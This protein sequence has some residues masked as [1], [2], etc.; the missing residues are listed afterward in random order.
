MPPRNGMEW[1]EGGSEG[2]ATAYVQRNDFI[3]LIFNATAFALSR[4]E[5]PCRAA[6]SRFRGLLL[7][8]S[9]MRSHSHAQK[10]PEVNVPRFFALNTPWLT[11]ARGGTHASAQ[12]NQYS[13]LMG[14]WASASRQLVELLAERLSDR[15]LGSLHDGA[16]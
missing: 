8:V 2:E 1:R 3:F 12:E 6:G 7:V 11:R 16:L 14:N 13:V 9:P 4:M 10:F 5:R 15:R